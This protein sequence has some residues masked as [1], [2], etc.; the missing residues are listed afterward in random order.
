VVTPV[1][2][3]QPAIKDFEARSTSATIDVSFPHQGSQG[4]LPRVRLNWAPSNE[5]AASGFGSD[6]PSFDPHGNL[7]QPYDQDDPAPPGT[8][9]VFATAFSCDTHLIDFAFAPLPDKDTGC[10]GSSAANCNSCE[11]GC[12]GDPIRTSNGNVRYTE[13]DPL[14]SNPG[15]RLV[16]TYDS[17]SPI[18]G[19][20]GTHW[21]SPFDA[22]AY[23][24]NLG[25]GSLDDSHRAVFLTTER[26]QNAAFERDTSSQPYR[27]IW[28]RNQSAQGKLAFDGTFYIYEADGE[29]VVRTYDAASG[30][31]TGYRS[32]ADDQGVTIGWQG[33]FPSTVTDNRGN[34]TLNIT[35]DG[36]LITGIGVSGQPSLQW[37]YV[38]AAGMLLNVTDAGANIWRTYVYDSSALL[39][40]VLDARGATIES[41]QYDTAGNGITS[42]GPSGEVTNVVYN[43]ADRTP[44]S[45]DETITSVTY[46][47]NYR[48][49]YYMRP[50]AGRLR[51]VTIN[52]PCTACDMNDVVDTYDDHGN[53]VR[54]QDGRGYI[55]L[56]TYDQTGSTLVT[57]SGPW[58]PASCDPALD[59]LQCRLAP[60]D[61]ATAALAAT[62]ATKT[63]G[64]DYVD[65]NWPSRATHVAS[66]SLLQPGGI[67]QMTTT[68]D[69]VSG[70]ALVRSVAGYTGQDSHP[71]V[72]TTT[73][74]LYDGSEG[75]A[76]SP[77]G[78]FDP[79]WETKPQP[80]ASRKSIDGPR[81]D[82]SDTTK[83]VYYPV[84]VTVPAILRG[85][86]AGVRNAMGQIV[87]MENYDVFG[88]ATRV[89]DA[90]GVAT[91]STYDALGRL[92]TSTLKGVVGCDT[93]ADP[94]CGT[95]LT[96]TNTYVPPTGPLTTS[97]RPSGAVSVYA[98]DDRGRIASLARGATASSLSERIEYDYNP[99]NDL[100]S[101]ERY[102]DVAGGSAVT[103][104]E[105]YTYDA[106]NRLALVTHD[107][108]TTVGYSY[109][110][111]G[112]AH[113][114][115]RT[116]RV[117]KHDE[118]LR[119]RWTPR[120]GDT[121]S[122]DCTRRHDL[123]PV[124]L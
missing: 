113:R 21:T 23:T 107:D 6:S 34:W 122:F 42:S 89:V 52:G 47:S 32:A 73:V 123:H 116:A 28:P 117:T 41:H 63:T 90:N 22:R 76:F 33:G 49:D 43:P 108:A 85:R 36:T 114:Q 67:R 38:H 77:G 10:D 103:R 44:R 74:S 93:A 30:L 104:R 118:Q 99:A 35:N 98:Y 86:L 97:S 46:G 45:P 53:V 14:P 124:R 59:S 37:S 95:D 65:P 20:F 88:N 62:T 50:I 8:I 5:I 18:A 13:T 15:F 84:D 1:V 69:A 24:I 48:A 56:F 71:E 68:Y 112:P 120:E 72:H 102:V 61:L 40:Q 81:S 3:R 92:L 39:E 94:L 27:Q 51:V 111:S 57:T 9:G 121:S 31:I 110:G 70:E 12:V 7:I 2:D 101:Q 80:R 26:N 60:D 11:K 19:F 119:S 82:V 64:Y 105:S 29:G 78:S 109:D 75:A 96:T 100:K 54:E 79:A 17:K 106:S 16:R 4:I 115:R 55:T 25:S 66:T 91:E 58:Q 83:Y 87:R